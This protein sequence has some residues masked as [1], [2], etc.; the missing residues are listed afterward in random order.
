LDEYAV[1]MGFSCV[2]E[3]QKFEG[4]HDPKIGATIMWLIANF[5]QNN[6]RAILTYV[7]SPK[8]QY[9]RHRFITFGK[10]YNESG[11]SERLELKKKI[12]GKTYCGALISKK[13]AL[14]ESLEI[15]LVDFNPEK[16]EQ[17]W[18]EVQEEEEDY[19]LGSET[20]N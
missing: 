13:N 16:F 17:G 4:E 19:N 3:I 5:F 8:N 20:I 10:W 1:Y 15:A 6:K 7:C 9:A 12:I 18:E 14:L 11:L 2:P